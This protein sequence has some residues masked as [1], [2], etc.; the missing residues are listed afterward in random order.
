M[1]LEIKVNTYLKSSKAQ[2]AQLSDN[3]KIL[4]DSGLNIPVESAQLKDGHYRIVSYLYEGHVTLHKESA[5]PVL[6]QPIGRTK[7]SSNGVNLIKEFEGFHRNA[8]QDPVGVWTIGYGH[9]TTVRS[10]MKITRAKGE[11][12]LSRDLMRFEKAVRDRVTVP[13]TQNQFD[14]LVSFAFNV[15]VGAFTGSTLLKRLNKGDYQGAAN[16][17][18]RWV[19]A[20][21]RRFKGLVRRRRRERLLFELDS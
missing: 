8:Y 17:L 12:L 9:T 20:G 18:M 11:Q 2:S 14:A 16:E 5:E 1:H 10:G 6:N 21:G 19:Y 13:L 7:I 3:E 4:L 15:G